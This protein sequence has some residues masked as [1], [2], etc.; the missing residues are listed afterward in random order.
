M[1]TEKF[2]CSFTNDKITASG[3]EEDQELLAI[4]V[5]ALQSVD[6][7]VV[8]VLVADLETFRF[9]ECEADVVSEVW[10]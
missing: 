8:A 4:D 1:I 5:D 10:Q 2:D 6:S 9:F 7:S 3:V